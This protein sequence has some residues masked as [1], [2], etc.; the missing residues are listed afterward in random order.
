[1]H[2]KD[3]PNASAEQILRD[4][5]DVLTCLRRGHFTTHLQDNFPGVGGQVAKV[6]NAHLEMLQNF[7]REHHRICE[8]VGV[9]GRLGGQAEV[10]DTDG[11]W[12]EMVD[13][14][15]RMS[16]HITA[17]CRDQG[18]IVRALGRG[19]LSARATCTCIQ[20]E[21]R[22]FREELNEL[23]DQFQRRSAAA[24]PEPALQ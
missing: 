17:Q 22:E 23:A 18:N 7:R 15:N 10:A 6:L 1:M 24:A 14:L 11:A 12:K 5:L 3:A 2:H 9:T 21:F 13:E 20:G 8:E 16:G 4:V 19:D